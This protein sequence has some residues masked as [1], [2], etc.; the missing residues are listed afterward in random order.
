MY[1]PTK[2]IKEKGKLIMWLSVL[3]QK[4]ERTAKLGRLFKGSYEITVLVLKRN[5]FLHCRKLDT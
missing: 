1:V 3:E 5:H 4:R 2:V